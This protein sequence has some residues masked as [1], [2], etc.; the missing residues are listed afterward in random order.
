MCLTKHHAVKTTGGVE[1][2]PYIHA[3]LTLVLNGAF[4]SAPRPGRFTPGEGDTGTHRM[5]G[6]VDPRDG[7]DVVAKKKSLPFLGIEPRSSGS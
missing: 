4:W 6:W 1:V 3:F 2:G 7:L 5:R